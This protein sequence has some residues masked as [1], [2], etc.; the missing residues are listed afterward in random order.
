[1][2][3]QPEHLLATARRTLDM[4]RHRAGQVHR[5]PR[6]QPDQHRA[7]AQVL[8]EAHLLLQHLLAV[9]A[10]RLVR[11]VTIDAVRQPGNGLLMP[12]VGIQYQV[13]A[14]ED[15]VALSQCRIGEAARRLRIDNWRDDH[16]VA[17]V[18]QRIDGGA[19]VAD[20]R[21]IEADDVAGHG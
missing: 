11:R 15:G 21:R 1:M 20:D 10:E 8:R 2:R 19:Q 13:R 4:S 6:V 7:V 12:L 5:A 17:T 16:I 18:G 3:S 9:P 14:T